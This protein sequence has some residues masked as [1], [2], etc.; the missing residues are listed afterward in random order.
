MLSRVT[1]RLLREHRELGVKNIAR[2]EQTD[3]E[4][5][6]P[7]HRTLRSTSTGVDIFI[8][9]FQISAANILYSPVCSCTIEETHPQLMEF[10]S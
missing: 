10:A 1:R 5:K 6:G 2:M 7:K 4:S 3:D 9:F 8:F